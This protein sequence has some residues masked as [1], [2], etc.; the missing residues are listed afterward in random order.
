MANDI[1]AL[2]FAVGFGGVG[3]FDQLKRNV[4][5]QQRYLKGVPGAPWPRD[6]EKYEWRHNDPYRMGYPYIYRLF[7]DWNKVIKGDSL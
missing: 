7:D 6:T 2:T 3:E 4:D 1:P 5:V